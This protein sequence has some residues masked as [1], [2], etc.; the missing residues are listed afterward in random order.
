[1]KDSYEEEEARHTASNGDTT[2]LLIFFQCL[3]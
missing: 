3:Q 1:M 2:I